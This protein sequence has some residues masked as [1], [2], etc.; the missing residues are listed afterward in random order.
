M[1]SVTLTPGQGKKHL[2]I[3]RKIPEGSHSE[4]SAHWG[5]AYFLMRFRYKEA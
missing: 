1:T 3:I 2:L 4:S 5:V